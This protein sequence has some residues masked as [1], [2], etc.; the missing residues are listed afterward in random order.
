MNTET[1]AQADADLDALPPKRVRTETLAI[2]VE[3]QFAKRLAKLADERGLNTS[4]LARMWLM[5]KMNQVAP[6]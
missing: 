5:E 6:L 1:N 4:T 2:R 3:A